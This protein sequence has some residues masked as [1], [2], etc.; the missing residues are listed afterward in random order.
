MN[1]KQL[2]GLSIGL[3]A[4]GLGFIAPLSTFSPAVQSALGMA[5]FA[6]A[7]WTFEPVPIEYSSLLLLLIFPLS[8]LLSFE[9]S[10]APFAGKTIWLI[11]A[12]M[13]LSMALSETGIGD[14]AA[15]ALQKYISHRPFA[16]IV[17]L[18]AVG[19][20][21]AFLVPSG[22]V[23]VLLLMPI[24]FSICSMFRSSEP[25]RLATTV[26]LSLVSS[27]IF[28][29]FGLLTGAV[30]NLVIAGQ[31]EQMGGI[32]IYWST[33]FVWMFPLVGLARTALSATVIWLL[34]A[35]D[36]APLTPVNSDTT[37]L[38]TL[39]PQRKTLA[40]LSLGVCLWATDAL[41]QI[42]PVYVA[43][44]LVL[45]LVFPRWGPLKSEALGKLNFPFLFYIAALFSLGTALDSSGFNQVFIRYATQWIELHTWDLPHRYYALTLLTV[46]LDFAMDIAA[47]AAVLTQPF[48]ELASTHGMDPMGAA[49]AIGMA[50]TLVFLPYQ[51][52][53]FMVAYSFKGFPLAHLV[54]TQFVVSTLSLLLI[55]PLNPL[56]WQFIGL[57]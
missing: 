1:I 54:L 22:V 29:G 42:A 20:L 27:T 37:R 52:A 8:G 12:G 23:R 16:L 25:Q 49:M 24:G 19:L 18:H 10:F 6:L 4:L 55:Y 11:F 41:H 21:T 44:F 48:I 57:I 28:G 36:L 9:Q 15:S 47:V 40:I 45:L 17:Q 7:F 56:L 32:P 46:P 30:P 35:R 34:F 38:T 31:V 3:G 53:P 33:W 50:T 26:L 5:V 13:A 2:A 51:A 43:L 14:L 39:L